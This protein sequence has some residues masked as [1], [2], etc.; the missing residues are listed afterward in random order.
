MYSF[1]G[2]YRR[3]PVQ[4]LGG[5]SKHSQRDIFLQRTQLERQKREVS[6]ALYNYAWFIKFEHIFSFQC[7]NCGDKTKVLLLFK[8]FFEG[9]N[10]D[11]F[12]SKSNVKSLKLFN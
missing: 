6:L 12:K 2:E 1:E 10:L 3:K 8:L 9:V 4:S 5:A 7:R 11:P